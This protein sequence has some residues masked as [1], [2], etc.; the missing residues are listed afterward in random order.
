MPTVGVL[1]SG[2]LGLTTL[3]SIY[4][5]H[6]VKFVLTD[7]RSEEIITFCKENG[8]PIF[9]GNPRNGEGYSFIKQL[10]VDVIASVNYLFL[11][12]KDI[13]EHPKKLCFNVHGSLLPRYRGRTPHVWAIINNEKETGITAHVIEEGCDTGDI[14]KQIRIPIEAADTGATILD[15]F[16]THYP[17]LVNDII[18]ASIHDLSKTPQDKSK[19]TYFG[20]RVPE[21]G[22]I[23]WN[24]SRERIYNWVR[25]M[26]F[27]YPGAYTYY[28]GKK[29]IIDSVS[30]SEDGFHFKDPNGKLLS[31]HPQPVVKTPNGALSLDLVRTENCIFEKEKIFQN[32]NRP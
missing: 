3:R 8:I 22:L 2:K 5:K 17:E 7:G 31:T 4:G 15:K 12:E 11:I 20:K 30:F 24:W 18:V 27:P 19:A 23:D 6:L 26:A 1:C 32:E 29:I 9:V 25:A 21:D 13:I 16:A 28:E 10:E 14:L